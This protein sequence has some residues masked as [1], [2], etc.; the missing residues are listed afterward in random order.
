[1]CLPGAPSYQCSEDGYASSLSWGYRLRVSS[2]YGNVIDGVDLKPTIT[3]VHDVKGWSYDYVFIEGRK[4]AI[5]ALQ[6]DVKK[7]FFVEALWTPIWGGTYNFTKDRDFYG[8]A[9]GVTF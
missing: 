3:F 1:M 4:L 9:I 6:A 7:R 8:L 5:V 2:I